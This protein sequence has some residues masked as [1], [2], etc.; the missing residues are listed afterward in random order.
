[1]KSV[2]KWFVFVV[3]SGLLL[4]AAPASSSAQCTTTSFVF[5][6]GSGPPMAKIMNLTSKVTGAVNASPCN[7][8]VY[9]DSGEGQA[10]DTNVTTSM[11][12]GPNKP[13]PPPP[14]PTPRPR[15][16]PQ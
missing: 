5:T 12:I 4:A 8:G 6:D 15:P 9:F 2:T 1:M 7:I 11:L 10:G 16:R 3:I 13:L 14:P